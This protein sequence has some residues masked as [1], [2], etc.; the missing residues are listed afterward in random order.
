MADE[1]VARNDGGGDFPIPAEGEYVAVCVDTIDL[2]MHPN[3]K[4]PGK[5]QHKVALVFQLGENNPDGEPWEIATRFTNSMYESAYLRKFLGLWRGKS[6]TDEEAEM[7]APLHKLV[8]VNAVVTIEHNTKGEKTYANIL[9]I[10]KFTPGQG[11]AKIAARDYVRAEYWEKVKEAG[12][13]KKPKP[14]AV[15]GGKDSWDDVP[16]KDEEDDLPF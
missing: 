14:A 5:L 13:L 2:G 6:Y 7:G 9:T 12:G 8:G 4:F 3:P 1:I 11:Q 16:L 10:R 15:G